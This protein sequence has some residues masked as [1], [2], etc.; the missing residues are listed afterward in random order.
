MM[1]KCPSKRPNFFET[2]VVAKGQMMTKC[3]SKRPNIWNRRVCK[4][5]ND[6]QMSFKETIYVNQK[7]SRRIKWLANC[8]SKRQKICETKVVAKG[9]LMTNCPSKRRNLWSRSGGKGSNQVQMSFKETKFMKQKWWQRVKSC[10][11]VLQ[12]D[13]ICETE[14]FAR[15]QLMTNC[16]SKRKKMC[17]T[18]VVAKG[19]IMT[20][21]PSKRPNLW[22][23][24]GGEGSNHV[25]MSVKET[26]Y[27]K[28]K[29]LRGVKYW[30][31]VLQR[32][33]ICESEVFAKD[34]MINQVSFKE[35]K[36]LW[37]RSG[38]EE[39]NDDQMSFEEK[40]KLWN[41]SGCKG[42]NHDQ[43]SCKKTKFVEQK[44]LR[45]I[46]WW[47]NVLQKDQ[48]CFYSFHFISILYRRFIYRTFIGALQQSWFSR[49]LSLQKV[50]NLAT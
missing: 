36:N 48:I 28:Q 31:N 32:D 16:P 5:L 33:H 50:Y 47:P 45:R 15:G 21:Y 19:Q 27:V 26:K 17:E 3:P 34:Q 44:W 23:R 4:G 22:S 24:S 9:Q 13:Q 43:M 11:N 18:E 37:N 30:P 1:T 2:D 29:C 42:S 10:P 46:K 8:A 49:S 40:K 12:R 35:T 14:V 20:K 7:C 39:S 6:D 38:R 25:Q 41:R